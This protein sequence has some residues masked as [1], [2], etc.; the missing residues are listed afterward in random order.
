VR[1]GGEG[2]RLSPSFTGNRRANQPIESTSLNKDV[3]L[4]LARRS[5]MRS[6]VKPRIKD[7][8]GGGNGHAEFSSH[9]K[10]R[11]FS[12]DD[13]FSRLVETSTWFRTTGDGGR[14]WKR[15]GGGVYRGN[16]YERKV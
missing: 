4:R 5:A 7:V 12:R 8:G 16:N 14:R 3:A 9:R 15:G 1:E 2:G 10:W 11:R 6:P 13:P